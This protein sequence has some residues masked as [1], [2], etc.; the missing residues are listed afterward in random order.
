MYA[1]KEY[2][3][4]E[5]TK[6]TKMLTLFNSL[7]EENKD[8]VISMSDSLVMRMASSVQE[9]EQFYAEFEG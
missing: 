3:K 6:K 2:I 1:Q 4:Q 7:S 9:Y 5:N 8:I